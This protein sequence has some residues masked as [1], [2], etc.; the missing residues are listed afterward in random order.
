[1]YQEKD[2]SMLFFRRQITLAHCFLTLTQWGI[3]R[4]LMKINVRAKYFMWLLITERPLLLDSWFSVVISSNS[5]VS[6]FCLPEGRIRQT[7]SH[8]IKHFKEKWAGEVKC[9]FYQY[10]FL[11]SD[12]PHSLHSPL[13]L[14]PTLV[15]SLD[16]IPVT[17]LL[18]H[19]TFSIVPSPLPPFLF[20]YFPP[21]LIVQIILF[22]GEPYFLQYLPGWVFFF[23]NKP[24]PTRKL[25]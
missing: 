23:K 7:L 15:F 5:V 11:V 21:F 6:L 19:F 2:S 3:H 25:M 18:F 24:I 4:D 16:V 22:E 8:V 17:F 12:R 13:F 9:I 10:H 20:H 1:M 14:F